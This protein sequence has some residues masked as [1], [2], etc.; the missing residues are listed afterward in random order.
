MAFADPQS[1][2]IVGTAYSFPR[3]GLG[4]DLGVFK[5]ST[6][7]YKLSIS[8]AINKRVRRAVRLDHQKNA[9]DPLFPAT[10]KPYNMAAYLVID[11]PLFGY[12]DAEVKGVTDALTLWLS[13]SSG[14]NVTKLLQ[15]E[16]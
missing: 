12:S 2:T 7:N 13:T 15:G 5:N 14:A 3:T 6:F 9:A 16:S 11:T 4:I 8:H 10:N 1:L